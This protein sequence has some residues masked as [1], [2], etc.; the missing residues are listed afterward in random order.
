MITRQHI[1]D[2]LGRETPGLGEYE[3]SKN[4][5]IQE[6]IDTN[7]FNKAKYSR[8]GLKKRFSE[9]EAEAEMKSKIPVSYIQIEN[10]TERVKQEQKTP[11]FHEL[12]SR[13]S[14]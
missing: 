12:I 4:L 6:K 11:S 10:K 8:F 13:M 2:F 14:N 9:I 1:V 3:T 7:S 5:T